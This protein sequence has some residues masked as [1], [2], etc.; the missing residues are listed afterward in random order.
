MNWES[1]QIS[2]DGKIRE[3]A[4]IT[5]NQVPFE[6][7]AR[8]KRKTDLFIGTVSAHFG[9]AKRTLLEKEFD[10]IEEAKVFVSSE[11][12]KIETAIEGLVE[13][14]TTQFLL[15]NFIKI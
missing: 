13:S 15:D 11:F 12:D 7:C 6:L 2:R 5:L 8:P 3:N 10:T 4:N 14:Q 9:F 1:T